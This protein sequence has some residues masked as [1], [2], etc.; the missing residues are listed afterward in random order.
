MSALM[1]TASLHKL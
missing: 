1:M